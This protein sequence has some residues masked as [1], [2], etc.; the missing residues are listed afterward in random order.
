MIIVKEACELM[1]S[2][3]KSTSTMGMDP[4]F[5]QVDELFPSMK[6][7][8][9]NIG[10]QMSDLK[11]AIG[12]PRSI[13]RRERK[14]NKTKKKSLKKSSMKSSAD[15]VGG[16]SFTSFGSALPPQISDHKAL[17]AYITDQMQ[18]LQEQQQ[19]LESTDIPSVATLY[20]S[21]LPNYM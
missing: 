18:V 13:S 16:A 3:N 19:I 9:S 4:P 7:L 8:H 2:V 15:S 12:N 14:L 6:K 1:S 11:A 10:D 5:R 20:T 17:S 21:Y